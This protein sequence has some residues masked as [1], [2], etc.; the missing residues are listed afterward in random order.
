MTI[1]RYS[2]SVY[3]VAITTEAFYLML[4][5]KFPYYSEKKGSKFCIIISW[6]SFLIYFVL[7]IVLFNYF[8]I[9][10]PFLWI[11]PWLFIRVYVENKW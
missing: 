9:V 2:A 1:F 6:G 10:L 11:L 3:S 8:K 5:L 4:L 7:C